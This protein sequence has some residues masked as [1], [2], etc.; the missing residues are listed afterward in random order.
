VTRSAGFTLTELLVAALVGLLVLAGVHR[1]FVAGISTQTTTSVQTEINRSAQVAMD[2]MMDRLRGSSGVKEAGADR[3]WFI[4]Q[5]RYHVRYWVQSGNLYRYRGADPGSYA[6]GVPVASNVS[7]MQ[8][9]YYDQ[10]GQPPTDTGQ[11]VRVT[12]GLGLTQGGHSARLKSAV[13]LR[14]K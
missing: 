10:N 6:G 8:F 14:N 4:D 13:K 3:V 2:D 7:D 11:V 12:A 9:S 5:D 1:I